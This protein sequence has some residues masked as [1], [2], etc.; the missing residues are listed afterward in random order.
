MFIV[1]SVLDYHTSTCF[2][3]GCTWMWLVMTVRVSVELGR[4]SV[5]EY[6]QQLLL[7]LCRWTCHGE[8]SFD[9]LQR[10]SSALLP[11][12]VS[13]GL[14]KGLLHLCLNILSSGKW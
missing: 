7:P 5:T 6:R 10:W 3:Q 13:P 12:A 4:S 9:G 14:R 2:D 11:Q 1:L 8:P